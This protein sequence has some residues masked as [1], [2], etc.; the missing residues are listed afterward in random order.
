MSRTALHQ[1]KKILVLG[2]GGLKIGQAGEFDYSGSQAL[3]VLRE[4][5][6]HSVLINPNI[7]TIQTSEGM[8]DAT[9]FLPI[10]PEYVRQVIEKERPDGIFLSFGGQTAL[11]CG[12]A[13]A[14]DG[15]LY[16]YGVEVLGTPVKTI[17]DTE[18]RQLFVDRL[19][20]IGAK[21]PRSIATTSTEAAVAAAKEI[22]YP[23]MVRVAYALGGAGSGLCKN[24]A[25]LR[26]RCDRAFAHAPQ[27]LVEEWLGGWKEIEY[28]V[29]RDRF[30][31]CITVCNM[32]NFDPL[33]IHTGESIVVAPSQTLTD[34]EYHKLRRIAIDV[35]RHLGIVGECNIQYALDPYSEDYRIIEVNARLSRSSALASKATGYPLAYVAAK[36]ALGYSLV[37]IENRI[38][39][40]TK[41][42]FEPALD[43]CVVKIPRWDLTKFKNVD[44]RIGSEMKSVGEVMSIGRTFEEALQKAIRMTG[45]GAPGLSGEDRLLGSEFKDLKEALAKP[46]DRRIFAI[47]RALDSGWSVDKIHKITKIDRWFLSKIAAVLETERNLR[48][49]KARTTQTRT[50]VP[51][52][53][54][55]TT[56]VRPRAIAHR[57]DRSDNNTTAS[58][59]D[60]ALLAQ[61]KRQGFS[62][63]RIGE[64]L[65]FP[66][67]RIRKL[68]DEYRLK[69]AIKQIDTLAAEYPAK[70]N[71]LYMT[72]GT[73]TNTQ[74]APAALAINDVLP[75][76][77]GV[78]VLGSGPYRI[79]SSVE[80]DWCCVN[81]VQTARKIGRYTIMVNCNPETVSTDYDVCDRLY[82]EEL[83]LERVL[84]IYEYEQPE[85]LI[86]SMGGQIPNNLATKL[87]KAG[88]IILG[89]RPDSIDMAEN[90]HK[91]SAL[92]DELGIEQPEW[93]ELTDLAS[94]KAFAAQVG[95]P[96]LIRPS[97]V[98]SGAAMNVAWDDESLEDYLGLAAEVSAEHPVVISKFVENSKEIEVDAV[99]KRGEI[100]FHAIT[101]HIENAGVHSGDATVVLPAQRLYIETIRKI[102]KI[103]ARIA[104]ALDITGPFNI[105]FLAQRNRVRV[106]ECN[107][108]ASRSFPFCSKVSRVNMIEMATRAMLDEPVQKAPASALD[109]EW[110]GVKAAQFSFSRLHGA[111]P[112]TGVEMASTG[113]VGCI[114]TDLDDAFLKAMLSVGYRIPKKKILLSTG[115]IE[116][117]VDFLDSARKLVEMGYELYGSRGTV[118]FLESNGVKATALNWPLESKE[119]NIATM[120]K[121]R[122]VDMVINIPKNNRQTELKNDY[123][124]RRLA[125]DFDIPLFTNIKVARQFIDSLVYKEQ[126]GLEIKAWEEYR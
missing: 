14:K 44:Q 103:T 115:P 70:T 116:D 16:K 10:T 86:L 124:I 36:L 75:A 104:Q 50:G 82:F 125:V 96:V 113:E 57:P 114:G 84:D 8:A 52:G 58:L 20:E 39:Q 59:P 91:F 88:T 54:P 120:I 102:R 2:S 32:E 111:D 4:E 66:E 24:E 5:G 64:I 107:L 43:Y 74:A 46:T 60:R 67:E 1:Y 95:Y 3:K 123:L 7:A 40:V 9:Y 47:Y 12:V 83:S 72:Y 97:Y 29:V 51:E 71:Y 89:T 62:D 101:E 90:R 92:L 33:G 6:I 68:R 53:F 22:G 112:V 31:N 73:T 81:T 77:R 109:L 45:I 21:T 27:V 11:N 80:F 105:Q 100:L 121:S 49:L 25:E 122:A 126:R 42:C 94:A 76:N 85:G 69:P 38:T 15:T 30:D 119:P 118:K 87:Y 23:V 108:R 56:A 99:A 18:D 61:A 41:S 19:N 65:G 17:E 35:I 98:L 48:Q 78:M 34:S 106:I 37:N 117:K 13:L 26:R 79:G 110:V 93:K 63:A 55:S 28:E